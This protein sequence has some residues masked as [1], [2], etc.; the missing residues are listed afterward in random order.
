MLFSLF[1]QAKVLILFFFLNNH[2]VEILGI[3]LQEYLMDKRRDF[4]IREMLNFFH[5]LF[6]TPNFIM[7]ISLISNSYLEKKLI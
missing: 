5:V 2:S 4:V 6:V 1:G 3:P 7:L